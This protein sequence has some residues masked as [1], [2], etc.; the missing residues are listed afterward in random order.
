MANGDRLQFDLDADDVKLF[1]DEAEEQLD[2]LDTAL[3]EMEGEPDPDLL[4]RIFRAAHTLKGSSATIGHTR[5][6]KL[7]HAMETVLDAVR[8]GQVVPTSYMVDKL[9]EGLD[10]LRVL[11]LEVTTGIESDAEIESLQVELLRTLEAEAHAPAPASAATVDDQPTDEGVATE[12]R[13]AIDEGKSVL[14]LKVVIEDSCQLP[15]IRC[16][17]VLQEIEALASPLWTTPER[18]QIEAGNSE[19]AMEAIVS[20][21]TSDE[22]LRSAIGA[23]MDV[24]AVSIEP[25]EPAEPGTPVPAVATPRIAGGTATAIGNLPV[26][27]D[28]PRVLKQPVHEATAARSGGSVRIEVERLDGLMNLVGELVIDRSRLQQIRSQLAS[29]MRGTEIA[30]LS[31]NFEETINHLA[32][33]TDELQDEIMRSRMLP[34]KSVLTRLPRLVRDVA[35]KC[36]KKVELVTFGEE[37]KLDRSVIEEISDPLVHVLRNAIDHG[38]ESPERR[39]ELGKPETGTVTDHG[40][41]P[42]DLHLP[43]RERRRPG[44]RYR[45]ASAQGGRER[46]RLEGSSRS[47]HRRAGDAVHLLRRPLD[48]ESSSRTSPAVASAWTSCG[49]TSSASTAPSTFAASAGKGSEFIIQLPLTLAT[50]KALMVSSNGVVYALPLVSVTEALSESEARIETT[51]NRATLVL[52]DALLPVVELAEAV[53]DTRERTATGERYVV[54]ASFGK[55]RLGLMVDRIL[56]EQDV[57]VKSLGGIIGNHPGVT[58]AT[59]LGDGSLGLII[60]TASLVGQ[61]RHSR[62]A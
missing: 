25:F 30:D 35:A 51:G 18:E 36:G 10:I 7:T 60:D 14:R 2:V 38:I 11:T 43:L 3:V 31:E 46:P 17:Q 47:R 45:H 22:E 23:V 5:M 40:L 28:R 4:Q 6:A 62:A 19:F 48:R 9:L 15:S 44:P 12:A 24:A 16:F 21:T 42:G 8:Q 13:A 41:E 33:I 56:G 27:M 1:S 61:G 58:G 39:R 49:R 34:I 29:M 20:T 53:G 55:H 52:R 50:T 37:T 59:I 54:A 26:A 57:V 32:R